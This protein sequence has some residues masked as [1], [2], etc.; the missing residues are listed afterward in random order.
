MNICKGT[1][2]QLIAKL[3]NVSRLHVSHIQIHSFN[4]KVLVDRA[5]SADFSALDVSGDDS[6]FSLFSSFFH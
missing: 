3:H 4:P 2:D 1:A 5:T 6:L